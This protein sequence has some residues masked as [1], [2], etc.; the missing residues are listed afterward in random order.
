MYDDSVKGI[1]ALVS[2]NLHNLHN[3]DTSLSHT[4]SIEVFVFFKIQT[5]SLI[6]KGMDQTW[7]ILVLED[8]F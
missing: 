6:H 4:S 1:L 8:T 2:D 3:T 5:M 7:L